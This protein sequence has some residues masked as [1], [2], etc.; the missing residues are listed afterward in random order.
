[1]S[2]TYALLG[3]LDEGPVH[4]YELKRQFDRY[5][6]PDHGLPFGQVYATLERLEKHGRVAIAAI[7]QDEGPE[8]RRYAITAAGEEALEEWLREPLEPEPHLRSALFAKVVLCVL[9]GRSLDA[10]LDAQRHAHLARMRELTNV[11]RSAAVPLALLADYAIFHL[12]ADLRWIELTGARVD[13]LR[14]RITAVGVDGSERSG[15]K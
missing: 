2:V 6:A 1:M 4:G 10:L 9:R 12:E 7:E 13:E 14:A 8:R 11:R 5:F 3:L 15:G